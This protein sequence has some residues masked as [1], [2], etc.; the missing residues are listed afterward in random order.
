MSSQDGP[1]DAGF[2]IVE[3]GIYITIAVILCAGSALLLGDAVYQ[4]IDGLSDGV[5]EAA[6]NTLD[7]LLLTFIFVELLSAVRSTIRVRGLLAEPFLLV[8]II[9]SIKEIIVIA[10]TEE[11][12]G[13][14]FRESMIEIGVLGGLVLVLALAAFL[15]RLKERQPEEAEA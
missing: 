2:R 12:H 6:A 8:G 11:T 13:D 9:A 4:L 7:A 15:L 3:T 1:I 10:G 5:D 14:A